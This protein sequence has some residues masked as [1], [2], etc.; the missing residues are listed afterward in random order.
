MKMRVRDVI[1]NLKHWTDWAIDS[2]PMTEAEATAIIEFF[3]E[4]ENGKSSEGV[5]RQDRFKSVVSS[6][7][8]AG[9]CVDGEEV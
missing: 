4:V 5:L 9:A 8:V 1:T 2:Y 7:P 3:E 6:V